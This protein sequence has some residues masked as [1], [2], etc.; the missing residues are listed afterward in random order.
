M[1]FTITRIEKA[2]TADIEKSGTLLD[3]NGLTK[4]L[5]G[6]NLLSENETLFNFGDIQSWTRAG[7]ET[8]TSVFSFQTDKQDTTVLVKAI[9]TTNPE[10]SLIDWTNRRKILSDN[11]IPV[12][13]W[14]WTGEATIYETYYPNKAEHT[15]DFNQLI[16]IAFRLDNLGFTTLKFTDDILC[17]EDGNPFYVDFGFD[18][19]EP[20]TDTKTHAKDYLIKQ[21]PDREAEIEKIYKLNSL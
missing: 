2:I 15:T 8:Y 5:I 13:N 17:D 19:G 12:S 20:S 6:K 14:F 21:F 1:D 10:K 9:V 11:N 7:G 16:E 3:Q 18:L 4:W